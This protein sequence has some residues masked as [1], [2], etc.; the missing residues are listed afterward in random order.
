MVTVRQIESNQMPLLD[1]FR[2]PLSD[3]RHWESFH[4]RWAGAIADS[5][6]ANLLPA[7]YYAEEQ[8]HVG[9][10]VEIDVATFDRADGGTAAGNGGVATVAAQTWAPPAP[11]LLIP[12]V[13]PDSIEVL[14]FSGEAGPTLVA[15]V[16]LVSPGNKDRA[17]SRRAFAAKCASYLQQVIGLVVVDIVTNRQANLHNELIRLMELEDRFAIS[18]GPLYAAAYRP[19]RRDK[20]E[21]LETWADPLA[22][23]RSLSTL[24]LALDKGL[25]IP[26]D[27][28][29]TYTEARQRRRMA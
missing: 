3:T 5:L 11:Q 16:G 12:A 22:I 7:G 6:N 13:F 29:T 15:A 19:A 8:V 2:P 23:D 9:G 28:E 20:S 17:Q 10:R 14:V 4:A 25:L 27:L 26:L 24:P 18:V 21:L 1:H